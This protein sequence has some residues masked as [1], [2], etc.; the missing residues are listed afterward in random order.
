AAVERLVRHGLARIPRA[1]QEDVAV[2]ELHLVVAARVG[3]DTLVVVV[4]GHGEGLLGAVLPDHVL[5]QHVL[6]FGGRGDLRDGFGDL[7][8]LIL[9]QDLIAERDA[10][11]ADVDRGAGEE[12]PD[13]ILGFAAERAAEVLIVRHRILV[14]ESLATG[15]RDHF[16]AFPSSLISSKFEMTWSI[17]P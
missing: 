12:F 8:L 11:I 9:G 7:A 14:W 1:N 17:N 5:I 6:D 2:V 15:A 16:L 4:D 3:V 13:R 10:L